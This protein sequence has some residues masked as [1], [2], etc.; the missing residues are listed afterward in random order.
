[1]MSA[2]W[3]GHYKAAWPVRHTQMEYGNSTWLGATSTMRDHEFQVPVTFSRR[4][5]K[6]PDRRMAT[7]TSVLCALSSWQQGQA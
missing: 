6:R 3:S 2:A 1:M 7:Q 4:K 5:K